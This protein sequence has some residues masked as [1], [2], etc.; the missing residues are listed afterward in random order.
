MDFSDTVL[1]YENIYNQELETRKHLDNK[2]GQYMT[3]F[4]S[5]VTLLAI[6]SKW[7]VARMNE[8]HET[9][10]IKQ[11][12]MIVI[13]LLAVILLFIQCI[14]Y[15]KCFFRRKK[16][17]KEIPIEDIRKW[18]ISIGRQ[19]KQK[20][21][22]YDFEK[23]TV[24]DQELYSYIRDSYLYCAMINRKTNQNR[25]TF[26]ILF[27][28]TVFLGFTLEIINY[29]MIYLKGGLTWILS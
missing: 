16:N 19:K 22:Y 28:N 10:T 6:Q 26:F 8:M 25:H 18:Y 12:I 27:E 29:Y 2:V 9:P 24:E 14:S 23:L 21:V 11:R 3:F 13:F 20:G 17:Y 4:L 15:Y 5:N 7:F 1:A